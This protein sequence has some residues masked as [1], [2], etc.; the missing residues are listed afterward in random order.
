MDILVGNHGR[1]ML[2]GK[3]DSGSMFV[4]NNDLDA[5]EKNE[6]IVIHHDFDGSL[7][8]LQGRDQLLAEADSLK[9]YLLTILLTFLLLYPVY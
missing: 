2:P 4:Y 9:E 3:S 6:P 7:S 1:S 8:I 5:D